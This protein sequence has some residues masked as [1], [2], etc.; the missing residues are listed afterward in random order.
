MG[1]V[2]AFH[3]RKTSC[4]QA[5]AGLIVCGLYVSSAVALWASSSPFLKNKQTLFYH[6]LTLGIS[7]MFTILRDFDKFMKQLKRHLYWTNGF[8]CQIFLSQRH[9]NYF[10]CPFKFFTETHACALTLLR[11]LPDTAEEEY[12]DQYDEKRDDS[13]HDSCYCTVAQTTIT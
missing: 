5:S 12:N 1:T 6:S 13:Y 7:D 4:L 11:S 10:I 2:E 8:Y 3:W 9:M